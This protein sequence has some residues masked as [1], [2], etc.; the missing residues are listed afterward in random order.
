MKIFIYMTFA[1]LILSGCASAPIYECVLTEFCYSVETY[2]GAKLG[3]R[4][5]N[6]KEGYLTCTPKESD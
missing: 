4:A 1:L 5:C 3:F 6:T 2:P